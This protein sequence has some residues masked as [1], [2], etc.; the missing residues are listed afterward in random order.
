MLIFDYSAFLN[1]YVNFFK[2]QS[3]YTYKHSNLQK[4][5]NQD[6]TVTNPKLA[7]P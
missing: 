4:I 6:L 3:T 1:D 2:I 5:I 7:E